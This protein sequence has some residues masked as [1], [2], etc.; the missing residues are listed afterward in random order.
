MYI[1]GNIIM[2]GDFNIALNSTVDWKGS[3]PID[4]HHHALMNIYNLMDALVDIWRSQNPNEIRH[5]KA[6]QASRMYFIFL[7]YPK[8]LYQ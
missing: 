2:V 5:L 4:S 8:K 3:P 1:E 7:L 6:K